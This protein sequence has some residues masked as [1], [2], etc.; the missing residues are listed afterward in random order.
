MIVEVF[1]DLIIVIKL[2]ML[3]LDEINEEILI[4][5]KKNIFVLD[6][7]GLNKDVFV[8]VVFGSLFF[9]Y[10]VVVIVGCVCCVFILGRRRN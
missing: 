7:L 5:Y 1:Y 2:I 3:C 9:V 4:N 10:F 6:R 8:G